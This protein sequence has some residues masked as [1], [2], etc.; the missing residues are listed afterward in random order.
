MAAVVF[1]Q[2]T[3]VDYVTQLLHVAGDT[4][5]DASTLN[6]QAAKLIEGG[7][8]GR[9][10]GALRRYAKDHQ[11]SDASEVQK[12]V[13]DMETFLDPQ[14]VKQRKEA[15]ARRA[16]REKEKREKDKEE[17]IASWERDG[18][19]FNAAIREMRADANALIYMAKV[20]EDSGSEP[21]IDAMSD[22]VYS[23]ER[24]RLFAGLKEAL[25]PPPLAPP[26]PAKRCSRR[27][28][29]SRDDKVVRLFND[30]TR[31]RGAAGEES[32]DMEA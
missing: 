9:V 27:R 30:T 18:H 16:E 28:R 20:I 13:D 23:A 17:H 11:Q 12:V 25:K 7:T 19:N 15:V 24:K 6:R 21:V 4:A 26:V 2:E 29:G 10:L 22:W 31:P 5:R 3:V 32:G 14:I 1:P 8:H